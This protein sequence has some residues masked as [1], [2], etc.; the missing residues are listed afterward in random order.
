MRG[1]FV[2]MNPKLLQKIIDR[3]LLD[4]KGKL[5]MS[6]RQA[7]LYRGI[8]PVSISELIKLGCV[9]KGQ[10][11]GLST[12]AR[13]VLIEHR[14]YDKPTAKLAIERGILSPANPAGIRCYGKKTHEEICKWS[15][16]DWIEKPK[17]FCPH[18]GGDL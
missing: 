6:E 7:S 13:N 4:A 11:A 2:F 18:C 12:R 1:V 10:H 14:I 8:G 3:F 15:G 16:A 17:K 9:L 5:P